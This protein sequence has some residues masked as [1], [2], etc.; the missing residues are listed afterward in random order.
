ME[1]FRSIG[2]PDCAAK[3]LAAITKEGRLSQGLALLFESKLG[4]KSFPGPQ[5]TTLPDS[6]IDRN[7][8]VGTGWHP[9][10]R[11]PPYFG[12]PAMVTQAVD[13]C[14]SKAHPHE[15]ADPRD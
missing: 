5:R 8:K 12:L 1:P 4:P 13:P 7:R 6:V 11:C 2:G 14:C 3:P 15:L 10:F 9:R